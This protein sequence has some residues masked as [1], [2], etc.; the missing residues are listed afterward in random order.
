MRAKEREIAFLI[1]NPG[2][3]THTQHCAARRAA[4]REAAVHRSAPFEHPRTGTLPASLVFFGYRGRPDRGPRARGMNSA[5]S[6]A[7][8]AARCARL[9]RPT[10]ATASSRSQLDGYS[11]GQEADRAARGIRHRRDRDQGRRGGR[12]ASAACRTG[13]PTRSLTPPHRRRPPRRRRPRRRR[14]RDA[15]AAEARKARHEHVVH[16]PDGRHVLRRRHARRQALRRHRRSR[17]RSAR[18]CASSRR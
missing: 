6:C 11:Q 12:C 9:R 14:G 5:T 2:A 8:R 16:R 13:A 18:C 3:F 4:G 17:S 15:A 10:D 7:V 1:F